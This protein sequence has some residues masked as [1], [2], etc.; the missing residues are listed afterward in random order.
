MSYGQ[1]SEVKGKWIKLNDLNIS[2]EKWDKFRKLRL[3][4]RMIRNHPICIYRKGRYI[5]VNDCRLGKRFKYGV[6]V[7]S[8]EYPQ[9]WISCSINQ[10][11]VFVADEDLVKLGCIILSH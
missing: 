10:I 4:C 11:E 2:D 3:Q 8:A 7:V 1:V 5:E 6:N 9:S